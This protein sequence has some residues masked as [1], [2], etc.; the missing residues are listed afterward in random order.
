M[1]ALPPIAPKQAPN[2]THLVHELLTER[3]VKTKGA[4]GL[5]KL[6]EGLTLLGSATL[7]RASYRISSLSQFLPHSTSLAPPAWNTRA[8]SMEEEGKRAGRTVWM[9][10]QTMS[11]CHRNSRFRRIPKSQC[12]ESLH[13]TSS[14]GWNF[15]LSFPAS[16]WLPPAQGG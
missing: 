8:H 4:Q 5:P 10:P 6:P 13:S 1:R 12:H 16:A 9:E 7:M 2:V 15:F 11:L 14:Q 3:S